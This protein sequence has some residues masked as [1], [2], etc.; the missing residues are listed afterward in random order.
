M[1]KNY[2][3]IAF[4]NLFKHKLYSLINIF[5]LAVGI[6]CTVLIMLYVNNEWSYDTFHTNSDHLYRA[7]VHEDYGNNEIYFNSVTPLVL[8]STLQEYI[9]EVESASRFCNFTNLVRKG[10]EHQAQSETISMA[11]P[12]FFEMFDFPLIKGTAE[13]VFSNPGSVVITKKTAERYFGESNVLQEVFSIRIGEMYEEFTV[14]GVI[15]NPPANSSLQFEFLIPFSNS[16]K[17]FSE[18]VHTSWFNVSTETYVLLQKGADVAEVDPK[19][20][21]MM[22]G[23]LG[24]RYSESN[25]TVGF[26]PI[27]DIHLNTEIPSGIAPVSDPTY[28]YILG[29]IALLILLIAC[30]NFMTLSISRSTSRAKE[31]G[32]RK[33]IGAIRQHLMY[34][35]WGEALLMTV[36]AIGFGIFIAEMLLPWFNSLSGKTL[37][38]G[39]SMDGLLFMGGAALLISLLSGIYPAL[40]LSGFKPVEVLKGRLNLSAD[41][42]L[43]RQSMVVFQFTL[44]IALIAG[45]LIIN[46]QLDYV[47]S[48]DLGFQKEQVVVL[49][50]N[51]QPGPGNP[52]REIIEEGNR[53]KERIRSEVRSSGDI[54][55]VSLSAYTPVQQGGWMEADFRESGGRKREFHFNIV[56]H[57]FLDTYQIDVIEGRDFSEENSSDAV[58]A[59]IVNQ[60]L[61][62]DYGWENPIGQRL[63]GPNFEDHEIVGVV[64][65]FHFESLHSQVEPLV[66]V[67]NPTIPFSGIDNIG[68]SGS[69]TPRIS[70]RISSDNIH[71][72]MELLEDTWT[73][74][75]SEAPFNYSFVDQAVDSQYRQE[76]RLS[77]IVLF[78]STLAIIIACLGL[79]GLA[80]L[81]VVRRTKE[82]G[83]RKVLG[84]S[85]TGIMMLV[86][87]E[88]TK[89]VLIGFVLAVP[90]T[91]Y[92]MNQWLQDFAY[93]ITIN[94]GVFLLAG[95]ITLVVAW[96][97][98]SY[99]SV[100]AT[101]INPVESL[102]SE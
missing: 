81:M 21:T 2:L 87:K 70:L 24:D 26:Q 38:L 89:L 73:A 31:V 76:E 90:M 60:A 32:I 57:R 78:G 9:P 36:L 83:V 6:A 41:K 72:T 23:V 97:T 79:F 14:T 91:W 18:N 4:R 52:L 27:T 33:T 99:Q 58:R 8:R 15:E 45:T 92:V 56:D 29:A 80:S 68:F 1:I 10:D 64:E 12:S 61:V 95:V 46:S 63:P 30:V 5:G 71:A 51:L 37:K 50:T 101:M 16:P 88:F 74:V 44:S 28:S 82:I 102:R 48:K 35:F 86:N 3:K 66:L 59:V 53:I 43:F 49:E 11:D 40:I 67:I 75:V 93:K 94:I 13:T 100:K 69:P 34:Q 20:K 98:V 85:S 55:G 77:Q 96:L 17:V 42:N 47:R 54:A 7:W 22:Q 62:D 65:N 19:L 84:A 25:Y 39:I